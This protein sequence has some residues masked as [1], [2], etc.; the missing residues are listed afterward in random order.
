[1][2]LSLPERGR[3]SQGPAR[4][5]GARRSLRPA[6]GGGGGGTRALEVSVRGKAGGRR[7]PEGV[8][9]RPERTGG[10]IK[11]KIRRGVG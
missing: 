4:T 2:R 9:H 10:G 5:C 3:R 6:A 8:K 11:L 7:R 1:M